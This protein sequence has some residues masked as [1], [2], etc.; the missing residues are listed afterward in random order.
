M[1]YDHHSAMQRGYLLGSQPVMDGYPVARTPILPHLV[2]NIE[3]VDAVHLGAVEV[4][5][6]GLI[7]R[8]QGVLE[9]WIDNFIQVLAVF[10]G[11]QPNYLD[12]ST[13]L[14]EAHVAVSLSESRVSVM[15]L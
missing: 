6:S 11:V 7:E 14:V 4:A 2:L 3:E 13:C 5:C 15:F 9:P 1:K 8:L 12:K 10:H